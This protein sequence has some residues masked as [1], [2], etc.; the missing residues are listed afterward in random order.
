MRTPNII[1]LNF[2]C[3]SFRRYYQTLIDV[4]RAPVV[5]SMRK[6]RRKQLTECNS[7]KLMGGKMGEIISSDNNRVQTRRIITDYQ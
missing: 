2:R 7:S 1:A 5:Q 6:T 4:I 3:Y